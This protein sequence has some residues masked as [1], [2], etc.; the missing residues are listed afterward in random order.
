MPLTFRFQV[1]PILTPPSPRQ[2]RRT[3]GLP[4]HP[5]VHRTGLDQT[6]RRVRALLNWPFRVHREESRVHGGPDCDD[7]DRREV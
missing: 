5:L 7:A 4:P 2:L 3:S 1:L 6:Q